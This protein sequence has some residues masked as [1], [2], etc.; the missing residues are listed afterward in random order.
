MT[1]VYFEAVV[2]DSILSPFM[3]YIKHMAS[4]DT[5]TPLINTRVLLKYRPIRAVTC[6]IT[7]NC[8]CF[9]YSTWN[10]I[11]TALLQVKVFLYDTVFCRTVYLFKCSN[12]YRTVDMSPWTH[13]FAWHKHF[14]WTVTFAWILYS[15]II[16]TAAY[17]VSVHTLKFYLLLKR[18]RR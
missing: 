18:T 4:V 15:Y 16:C 11:F 14:S 2:I 10:T 7:S 12:A 9:K 5:D 13:N 1:I 8:S 6:H 17:K 3:L